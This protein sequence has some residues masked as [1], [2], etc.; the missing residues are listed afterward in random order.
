[1]SKIES[2]LSARLF[3]APQ[4]A[5]DRIFFISNLSGHLSLYSMHENGSVPEPLIPPRI[6]LQN[7]HLMEGASF[8]VFPKLDKI[9]VMIDSDGDENYEPMLVPRSGGFPEPA[10]PGAFDGQRANLV[11]FDLDRNVVYVLVE[12]R[13]RPVC[14]AFRGNLETGLVEKLAESPHGAF[15]AGADRSHSKVAVIDVHGTGDHVLYLLEAG[16]G[17][18]SVLL[19]TPPE[20]R[21]AGETVR[22]N[23]V[24]KC[25][26][27]GEGRAIL[28]VT[29]LWSDAYGLGYLE[30]ERPGEP[31]PVSIDGVAHE[32]VGELEQFRHVSGD[33]YAVGMNVDGDSWLYEATFDEG[34]LVMTLGS[35][36]CGKGELAGG[37]LESFSYD[38]AGDRYVL[39]FSSATSPSQIYMIDGDS[40]DRV[41]LRTHERVLGIPEGMLAAGEDA[42][43]ESFDGLRVSARLYLPSAALGF[44][45]PRPLVYYIHGGPQSQ[46]RPDFAWF[47]MPLIQLLTLSGFAVF[48]PNVR[49]S[50]GYG[51]A[52]MKMVERDWGGDDALD[53][54][55]AVTEVLAGDH[56]IDVGRTGIVGRS[57]GGFMT[58]TLAARHPEL[59]AA[60]V[61]MFGPYDLIGFAGRVPEAW[62]PYNDFLL[63]NPETDADLLVERSPR[64]HIG[65]VS[66]PLLV[67]Q[68][69]NDP[70]VLEIESRELVETLRAMGKNVDY[71]VFEDEGHD[72]IKFEN[73]VRCYT[74]ISDFFTDH[75][76]P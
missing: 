11:D 4:A 75:L 74:A 18:R 22:P 43:Y 57:Y 17:G 14:T 56:R 31:R 7:P 53:H 68:G 63:G 20:G 69:R 70:R 67:I 72:V 36:L 6:A 1:M 34:K 60:A 46:E 28:F 29:S 2:I 66:C 64:T 58:L 19:G 12:S 16:A 3:V 62:K 9:L 49:G 59:W 51:L 15:P 48:V 41:R 47:S 45:G 8:I 23:G 52:Y 38:D 33:R 5:G 37:V 73:R 54:V 13:T 65:N 39:S 71:L 32:G 61:D 50:A 24:S 27:L 30:L 25:C 21:R 55:H 10:F 40:R 26:F 35:V 76:K 44:E 42:S